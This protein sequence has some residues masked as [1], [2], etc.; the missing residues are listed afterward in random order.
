MC[1]GKCAEYLPVSYLREHLVT[2]AHTE[3][4]VLAKAVTE[5]L[6]VKEDYFSFH[7]L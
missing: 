6:S 2:L 3:L 5:S 1:G 4:R 7:F